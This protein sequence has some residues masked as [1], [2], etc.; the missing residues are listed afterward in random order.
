MFIIISIILGMISYLILQ[1]S[2]LSCN[3]FFPCH[4]IFDSEL[5]TFKNLSNS[6]EIPYSDVIGA[7]IF[8]IILGFL[9]TKIDS[10]KIIN[11]IARRLKISFKYGDENL[12]TYFLNSPE[13]EWV[14]VRDITNSLTYLGSVKAFSETSEF[15]EIV[16]EQVIVY[17]YPNSEELYDLERIYLCLPKERIIIEQAK[18]K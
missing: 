12:Y 7:S 17:S 5:K 14:Y 13:T 1:L 6:N 4:Q 11:K 9:A 10:S 16:L 3:F 15:K 8:S 18:I 2:E